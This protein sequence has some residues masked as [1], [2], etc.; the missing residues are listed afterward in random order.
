M[1]LP[2]EAKP[3]PEGKVKDGRP[4]ASPSPTWGSLEAG[5]L[6]QRHKGGSLRLPLSQTSVP[7]LPASWPAMMTA[8]CLTGRFILSMHK[9][10]WSIYCVLPTSQAQ[11]H[12]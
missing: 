6:L 9:H 10:V 5:P 4:G 11:S 3:S 12:I 8:I 7:L 2:L 1:L